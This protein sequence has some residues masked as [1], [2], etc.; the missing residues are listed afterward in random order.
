VADYVKLP[1]Y[2]YA[3]ELVNYR[4]QTPAVLAVEVGEGFIDYRGFLTALRAGGFDGY[5][6]YEMCS[7]L[8]GGGSPENLDR[9]ARQF[10]TF[11]QSL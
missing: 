3:P 5:V 10:L 8:R 9:C 1:R 2:A 6:A 7:P 11:I 4:E